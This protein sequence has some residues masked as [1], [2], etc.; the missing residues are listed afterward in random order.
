M[1]SEADEAAV[2]W[3]VSWAAETADKKRRRSTRIGTKTWNEKRSS[4]RPSFSPYFICFLLSLPSPS[5]I[6]ADSGTHFRGWNSLFSLV[7]INPQDDRIIL[8]ET[9]RPASSDRHHLLDSLFPYGLFLS[10]LISIFFS[11][12]PDTFCGI[13]W[14]SQSALIPRQSK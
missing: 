1:N 14:V 10:C 7:D 11:F 3:D 2:S 5:V 4:G 8:C 12:S 9:S 13:R 6:Y